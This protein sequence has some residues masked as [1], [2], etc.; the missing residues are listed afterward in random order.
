[1]SVLSAMVD[2]LLGHNRN[3]D[4][5]SEIHWS[6]E[7]VCKYFLCGFC[8]HD[9][10]TNTKADLGPCKLLHDEKLLLQY[11]E[12]DKR[13]EMGY[14]HDFLILLEGIVQDLTRRLQRG[15]ERLDRT[16]HTPIEEEDESTKAIS[17]KITE[18]L[19]KTERLGSEGKIDAAQEVMSEVEIL[20]KEKHGILAQKAGKDPNDPNALL[21]NDPERRLELCQVCGAF[22]IVNDTPRRI[23]DHMTGKMH[24]GYAR[25]RNTVTEL[26]IS[27]YGDNEL[28]TKQSVKEEGEVSRDERVSKK[29]AHN[30]RSRSPVDKRHRSSY[31][32]DDSHSESRSHSHKHKSSGSHSHSSHKRRSRDSEE[33]K[34]RSSHKS[35]SR[36]RRHRDDRSRSRSWSGGSKKK[37]HY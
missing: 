19:R 2:D 28:S 34:S 16:Y 10:F 3:E 12:S 17:D 1:M 25:I 6:D 4:G 13:G 31:S 30:S 22:L 26:K 15:I 36:D 27:L 14:E 5:S 35:R 32:R 8:P 24:M 33:R 29:R 37:R 20:K 23:N 7:K 21:S 9:L 18:L 11:N